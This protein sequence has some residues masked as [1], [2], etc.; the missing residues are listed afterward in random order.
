MPRHYLTAAVGLLFQVGFLVL[1][2]YFTTDGFSLEDRLQQLA[3]NYVRTLNFT[4][5]FLYLIMSDFNIT[6]L[7]IG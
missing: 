4:S 6:F 1:A 5:Y 3:E 2:L 7:C